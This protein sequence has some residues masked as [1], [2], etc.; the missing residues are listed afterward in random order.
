MIFIRYTPPPGALR[1]PDTKPAGTSAARSGSGSV[2]R[3]SRGS[4]PS[5]SGARNNSRDKTA[6]ASSRTGFG[7]AAVRNTS[8]DK[9][10]RDSSLSRMSANDSD[11]GHRDRRYQKMRPTPTKSEITDACRAIFGS[12]WDPAGYCTA[13]I[14][15]KQLEE[16]MQAE[17]ERTLSDDAAG[18]VD[19]AVRI[20]DF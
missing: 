12:V 5:I 2:G 15:D 10:G 11:D 4:L 17:L 7:S 18:S 16:C 14:K 19:M 6:N 20:F 3:S 13:N 9:T 8:R 1:N